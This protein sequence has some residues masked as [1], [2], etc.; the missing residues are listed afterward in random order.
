HGSPDPMRPF[1]QS[2]GCTR[3]KPSD[4]D[5]LWARIKVGSRI[6]SYGNWWSGKVK[7][8]GGYTLTTPPSPP[9]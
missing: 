5:W 8:F 9:A 1:P 2:H 4:Q 7:A 3:T 6:F